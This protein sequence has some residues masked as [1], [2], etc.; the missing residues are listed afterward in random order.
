[1]KKGIDI[2]YFQ[3]NV[4]FNKV[5]ADGIDFIIPRDGYGKSTKDSKFSQYVADAI[6]AGI[7]VP[8][9]YH[10]SYALSED[11]ARNEARQAVKYAQEAGLPKE[12]IIFFDLQLLID[13][14]CLDN[15]LRP[16]SYQEYH[17]VLRLLHKGCS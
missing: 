8:G 5:K 6:K 15:V 17:D 14:S 7:E 16:T 12:T 3:G 13:H 11:D 9:I 1:M 4:D 10:F 2:S